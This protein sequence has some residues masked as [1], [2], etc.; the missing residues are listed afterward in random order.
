[1]AVLVHP[2]EQALPPRLLQNLSQPYSN[3]DIEQDPYVASLR[4][5]D[6]EKYYKVRL[7]RKTYCQ[8]QMKRFVRM[9]I[10]VNN[11]LGP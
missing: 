6:G 10:E 2:E 1:M 9:A 8:D 4:S 5:E 3:L 11:E 7:S